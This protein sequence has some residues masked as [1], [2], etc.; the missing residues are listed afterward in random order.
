M[1]SLVFHRF[2][3]N[4]LSN[5]YQE[6]SDYLNNLIQLTVRGVSCSLKAGSVTW[7]TRLLSIFKQEKVKLSA[8]RNE[9]ECQANQTESNITFSMR[10]LTV[11]YC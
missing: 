3:F 9:E 1:A 7:Q 4:F 8:Y 6:Q 11:Q 10:Y 5:Y 2:I